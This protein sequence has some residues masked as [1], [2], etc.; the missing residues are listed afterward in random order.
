MGRYFVNLRASGGTT[1]IEARGYNFFGGHII[2][3][4]QIS[5]HRAVNLYTI[6]KKSYIFIVN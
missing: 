3:V 4:I 2:F 5:K 6:K 1:I